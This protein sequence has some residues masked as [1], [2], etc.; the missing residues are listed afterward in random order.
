[1]KVSLL[2][3]ITFLLELSIACQP[4]DCQNVDCGTCVEACCKLQFN[5]TGA[6]AASLA[7]QIEES[8]KSGGPDS[9]YSYWGTVPNQG[10]LTYV[11]QGLH[12]TATMKYNDTLN[13]GVMQGGANSC[14]VQAFSHSQDFIV[15][16]FAYCDEGQNYKN[17]VQL[18]KSLGSNV[19]YEQQILLGCPPPK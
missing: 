10:P 12:S 5:I 18:I 14:A 19:K 8:L 3:L 6:N 13:F 4:P 11:V 17:L 2:L 1:M 9:S 16:D 15:G 7:K